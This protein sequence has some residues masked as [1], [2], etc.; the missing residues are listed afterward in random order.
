MKKYIILIIASLIIFTACNNAT[1]TTNKILETSNS[2][3]YEKQCT[4]AN[5]I[6]S[7]YIFSGTLNTSDITPEKLN[8]IKKTMTS[9]A[10]NIMQEKR[11][12]AKKYDKEI[13]FINVSVIINGNEVFTKTD[14]TKPN[15][16]E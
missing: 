7:E 3:I 4:N 10:N 9:A 16:M 1:C 6:S 13:I 12:E 2:Q 15:W 8:F 11:D 14:G 5:Y